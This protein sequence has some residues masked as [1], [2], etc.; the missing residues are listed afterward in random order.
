[1]PARTGL[2]IAVPAHDVSRAVDDRAIGVHNGEDRD[3]C[4][5]DLTERTALS[6]E[7]RRGPVTRSHGA[8][9]AV[10]PEREAAGLDGTHGGAAEIL[11]RIDRIRAAAEIEDDRAPA[12]LELV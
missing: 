11:V 4:G 2:W 6:R 8:S 5:S 7:L 1:S 10:R 12:Q 9:G 3:P